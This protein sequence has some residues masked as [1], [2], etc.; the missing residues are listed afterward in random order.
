M[1]ISYLPESPANFHSP[2]VQEKLIEFIVENNKIINK[3]IIIYN[4]L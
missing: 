2:S 1:F 4:T 3:K